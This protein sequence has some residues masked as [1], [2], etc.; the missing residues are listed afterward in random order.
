MPLQQLIIAPKEVT[1]PAHIIK[2][3]DGRPIRTKRN[4]V[5]NVKRSFRPTRKVL[6]LHY[7]LHL[8]HQPIYTLGQTIFTVSEVGFGLIF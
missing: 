3:L 8:Q 5:I 4:P 6:A 1:E 2:Y 7:N